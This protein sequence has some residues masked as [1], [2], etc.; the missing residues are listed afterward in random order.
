MKKYYYLFEYYL[1]Y[2]IISIYLIFISHISYRTLSHT[3][4]L[5]ISHSLL[6]HSL[7]S[8]HLSLYGIHHP[9]NWIQTVWSFK[10]NITALLILHVLQSLIY[11]CKYNLGK[12]DK[13]FRLFLLHHP[14][15]HPL[16]LLHTHFPICLIISSVNSIN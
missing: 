2:Y 5:L 16:V 1:I 12:V 9:Q 11:M 3:F 10:C 13:S 15:L 6:F 8:N 4:P 14:I 7:K